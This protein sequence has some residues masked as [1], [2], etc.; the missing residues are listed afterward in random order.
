MLVSVTRGFCGSLGFVLSRSQVVV[1]HFRSVPSADQTSLRTTK[2]FCQPVPENS[3]QT[4]PSGAVTVQ[5]LPS[6]LY[7][8]GT[9]LGTPLT[10][11]QLSAQGRVVVTRGQSSAATP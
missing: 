6:K 9:S 5:A 10:P 11:A 7:C 3:L 4:V 8:V 2:R 1:V